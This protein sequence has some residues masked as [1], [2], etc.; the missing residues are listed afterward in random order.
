MRGAIDGR[1]G[2]AQCPRGQR[3]RNGDVIELAGTQ[4]QFISR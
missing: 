3:L 2:V 4:M 1:G